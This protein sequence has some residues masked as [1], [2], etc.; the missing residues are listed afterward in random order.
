MLAPVTARE[1]TMPEEEEDIIFLGFFKCIYLDFY[2]PTIEDN[3]Y[4]SQYLGIKLHFIFLKD[5]L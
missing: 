2:L 5:I 1:Q 3:H 4:I